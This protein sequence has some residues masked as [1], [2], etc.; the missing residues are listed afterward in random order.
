[1]NRLAI[2]PARYSSTRYPGK[3]LIDI[4]GKPMIQWVYERV[5]KIIP[6]TVV[7]TDDKL[8]FDSVRLFGGIAIMTSKDHV[9]G[10]SRCF[11]AYQKIQEKSKQIIHQVINV[12]GDE[13][14]IHFE[15]IEALLQ[16]LDKQE[17]QIATLAKKI[18]N[19]ADLKDK[20]SAFVVFNQKSKALYFSRTPL[21]FVKDKKIENWLASA[22]FYKHIGIYGFKANILKDLITLPESQLEKMEKLEQNRWLDHGYSIGVKVTS[23]QIISVDVPE[24]LKRV[25]EAWHNDR[26]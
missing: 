20:E 24:D 16:Q 2:I 19:P 8:I 18:E 15:Q 3:P 23:H 17:T 21:P 5:K 11:E 13:P 14:L 25:K 12:Q 26:L 10:T 22:S 9:N 1:M 7:A 4:F 6:Q